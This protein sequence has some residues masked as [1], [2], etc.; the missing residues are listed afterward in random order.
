[1]DSGE[2][3]S[4]PI[5][6]RGR[7]RSFL[8]TYIWTT[9]GGPFI[10]NVPFLPPWATRLATYLHRALYI[11]AFSHLVAPLPLTQPLRPGTLPAPINVALWEDNMAHLVAAM[12]MDG[13]GGWQSGGRC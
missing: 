4:E 7:R 9:S 6:N 11:G 1:M 12:I 8:A 5:W 3:K 2:G 10:P 13:R